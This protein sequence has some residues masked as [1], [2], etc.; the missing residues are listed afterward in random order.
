MMRLLNMKNFKYKKIINKYL[1]K[2]IINII[3]LEKMKI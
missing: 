1:N 2:Q 3:F